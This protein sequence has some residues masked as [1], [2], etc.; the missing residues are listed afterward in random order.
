MLV[1]RI[2]LIDWGNSVGMSAL[3]LISCLLSSI[4]C[5]KELLLHLEWCRVEGFGEGPTALGNVDEG[6]EGNNDGT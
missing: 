3:V 6:K 4:L 1:N 2:Y 5:A